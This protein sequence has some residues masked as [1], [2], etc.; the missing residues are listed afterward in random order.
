MGTYVARRLV[1]LIPSLVGISLVVFLLLHLIPGDVVDA[2]IGTE[3]VLSPDVRA[4]LRKVLGLDQPLQVQYLSWIW[5]MLHG[6]LGRSLRSGQPVL[7]MLL[8][9]L[10][11]TAEL[12]VLSLILSIVLSI[13][14]GVLSAVRRNSWWDLVARLFSLVGLSFPT[15]WLATIF[16]LVASLYFQWLPA[17]LF[18]NFRDDP[19][20]NL[21]QMFLPTVSLALPLMAITSRLTRSAMLEVLRQEYV[22][23]ARAKGLLE[24]VVLY[25]HALRNA[26]I[27]VVTIVGIQ[28]GQLFGGAVVVEQIFGLPGVGLLFLT[29]ISQ[30]DYPV[31]QGGVMFLATIF[32]LLNVAVDVL[33]GYLDPR[34]H[35]A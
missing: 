19:L 30:R 16:I 33:Y 34:I 24:R 3:G 18:V 14:L 23:T 28:L 6:D 4:S 31:V 11:V 7:S 1:Q 27:P 25:R 12:S 9:R 21:E 20:A 32:L 17:V 13:P 5:D 2:L 10:P 8:Q 29:G 15:F 26:L 35:Y 22:R